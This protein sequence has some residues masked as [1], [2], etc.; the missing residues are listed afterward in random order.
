[1]LFITIPPEYFTAYPFGAMTNVGVDIIVLTNTI[2]V[3]FMP[4][5]GHKGVTEED[6][7][8]STLYIWLYLIP[9]PLFAT[10]FILAVMCFRRESPGFYVHKKDKEHAVRALRQIYL[11]ERKSEYIKRYKKLVDSDEEHPEPTNDFLKSAE[12][13][14]NKT[15]NEA[16]KAESDAKKGE[17]DADKAEADLEGG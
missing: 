9:V 8:K 14:A 11:G 12:A 15:T 10:A 5:A 13:S 2:M 16:D 6:L 1:M 3:L 17:K 7:A 4:K